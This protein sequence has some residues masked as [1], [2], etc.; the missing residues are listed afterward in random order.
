MYASTNR[1]LTGFL[2][3]QQLYALGN[4]PT[5]RLMDTTVAM[6]REEPSDG[7]APLL[8]N[9]VDSDELQCIAMIWRALA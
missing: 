1:C 8:V 6:G 9:W 3:A 2:S 4:M 7:L 5:G